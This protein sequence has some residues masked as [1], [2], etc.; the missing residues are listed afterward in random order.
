MSFFENAIRTLDSMGVAT[1]VLPFILL[2]AIVYAV[3]MRV[4]LFGDIANQ[5]QIN[6]AIALVIALVPV[7]Q[8]ALFPGS[9]WD[10]ITII[11]NALADISIIIVAVV[12]LLILLGLWGIK[13][14]ADGENRMQGVIVISAVAVV[15][16]IFASQYG[17]GWYSLP[18]FIDRSTMTIVVAIIIFGLIVKFITGDS[19][20]AEEKGKVLKDI[21][22]LFGK[23]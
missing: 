18:Y 14:K 20:P 11:N 16:L 12:M 6:I 5:K 23:A 10:V 8:H 22:D 13:P 2:F 3:L 4:K 17:F 9:Q 15:A 1:I 21:G 19:K 7:F